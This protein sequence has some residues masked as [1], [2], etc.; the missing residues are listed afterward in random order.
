MENSFR[1]KSVIRTRT[2]ASARMLFCSVCLALAGCAEPPR[3]PEPVLPAP[4]PAAPAV[5]VQPEVLA[6][7]QDAT[8]ALRAAHQAIEQARRENA[9]WIVAVDALK[10]ADR[11]AARL[12]SAATLRY[13]REATE[14]AG[15]GLQQKKYPLVKEP[16]L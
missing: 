10:Q 14:F 5:A 12:D 4:V 11:A 16:T 2:V 7:S 15:L 9:L 3:Q 1:G 8:A 6:L 13:A